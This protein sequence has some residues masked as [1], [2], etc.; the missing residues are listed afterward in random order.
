MVKSMLTDFRE[1]QGGGEDPLDMPSGGSIPR[2]QDTR[3]PSADPCWSLRSCL[4]LCAELSIW[5]DGLWDCP[6]CQM[7]DKHCASAWGGVWSAEPDIS[8][9]GPSLWQ[10][11][12][13]QG[14]LNLG[15]ETCSVP[16][17][18]VY[19][20]F[21]PAETWF[22]VARAPSPLHPHIQVPAGVDGGW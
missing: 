5:P 18:G 10:T 17:W 22:P 4:G 11:A 16:R 21:A 19:G 8:S 9:N 20:R 3:G 2:H 14:S 1:S 15:A 6:S 13:P 7:W 12:D